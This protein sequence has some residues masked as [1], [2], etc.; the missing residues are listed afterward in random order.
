MVGSFTNTLLKFIAEFALKEF[1]KSIDIRRSYWLL[2]KLTASNAM[3][4]TIRYDTVDLLALKSWRDGQ[5]NLA[6]GPETKN[7]VRRALHVLLKD[8][9]LAWDL[10][11]GGQK[12]L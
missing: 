12:L 5:L 7:N 8:E 3:C 11:Y 2:R 4:D 9:E 1:L 10:T 6:H